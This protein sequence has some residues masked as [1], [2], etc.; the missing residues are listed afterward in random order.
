MGLASKVR[1]L[2]HE[3]AEQDTS[4][5]AVK[6]ALLSAMRDDGCH[7]WRDTRPGRYYNSIFE[8]QASVRRYFKFN[9]TG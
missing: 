9:C 2:S 6:K 5:D 1:E 3:S 7:D 4:K 8:A